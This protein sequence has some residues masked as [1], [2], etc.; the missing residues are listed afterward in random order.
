MKKFVHLILFLFCIA[1][2]SFCT[3]KEYSPFLY[4]FLFKHSEYN[5]LT[6][7]SKNYKIK[8][9]PALEKTWYNF[10]DITIKMEQSGAEEKLKNGQEVENYM[11]KMIEPIYKSSTFNELEK[12][13]LKNDECGVKSSVLIST[14]YDTFKNKEKNNIVHQRLI[15]FANSKN[16]YAIV[17]LCNYSNPVDERIKFCE[18]VANQKHPVYD[19]KKELANDLLLDAYSEKKQA[20]KLLNLCE[21]NESPDFKANCYLQLKFLTDDLFNKK[22]NQAMFFYTKLINFWENVRQNDTP[23][24]SETTKSIIILNLKEI[25]FNL[26]YSDKFIQVCES[27]DDKDLKISCALDLEVIANDLY[28]DKKYIQ[29]AKLYAKSSD[30]GDNVSSLILAEMNIKGIGIDK[31][32]SEALL[33]Y[34]QA[35]MSEKDLNTRRD[36]Y[37]DMG[38]ACIGLNKNVDAFDYFQISAKMGGSL[39]QYHLGLMYTRGQGVIADYKQAYA[40]ISVAL[41]QGIENQDK[42][43]VYKKWLIYHLYS[44]D[45]TGSSFRE[46]ENL[47]QLYY[48]QY[49]SHGRY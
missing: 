37:N 16:V 25:Y 27:T 13:A 33:R 46:A 7:I 38:I 45:P 12:T 10:C 1:T 21:A 39:A 47:A 41:A 32:D 11:Q 9:C 8:N 22:N 15:D 34:K 36:I 4:L 24:Y 29:A 44:Q 2:V 42:A 28:L 35:L 6:E 19:D 5:Y 26:R 23:H 48:K 40:W 43:L 17:T 49:V 20:M 3:I 18:M 30:L 14:F 31:N